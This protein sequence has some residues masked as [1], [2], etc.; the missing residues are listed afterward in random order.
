MSYYEL[1]EVYRKS[2]EEVY[3]YLCIK[4]S[5]KRDKEGID[6][7]MKV[8]THLQNAY[9]ERNLSGQHNCCIQLKIEKIWNN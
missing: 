5:K 3:S 4:R 7:V 1:R 9:L 6:F 8:K 2:W